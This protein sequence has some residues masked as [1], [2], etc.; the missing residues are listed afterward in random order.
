MLA[1]YPFHSFL[2]GL[3]PVLFLFVENLGQTDLVAILPP[4]AAMMV[5]LGFLLLVIHWISGDWTSTGVYAS[6]MVA[7]FYSYGYFYNIC[8]GLT[9]NN[10][11]LGRERWLIPIWGLLFILGLVWLIKHR[12]RHPDINRALNLVMIVL[13]SLLLLKAGGRYYKLY[14]TEQ[15]AD[16]KVQSKTQQLIT[17]DTDSAGLKNLPSIYYIILDSYSASSILK[18]VYGYDNGQFIAY[19]KN[20]GFYVAE[21]SCCNYAFTSASL[22]SSLNLD[23]LDVIFNLR[24]PNGHTI[25]DVNRS[26][27]DSRIAGYFSQ[28]GYRIVQLGSWWSPTAKDKEEIG[29]AGCLLTEFNILLLRMTLLRPIV[30]QMTAPL[31]RH[32]IIAL[33]D[34]MAE[35]SESESPNFVFAHI[36]C[37]HPPYVFGAN[38]EAVGLLYST[39]MRLSP[40]MLYVNQMKAIN[41]KMESLF[42]ILITK[43]KSPPIIVIQADHGSGFLFHPIHNRAR[44]GESAEDLKF[45]KAQ[46]RI[47][48]AYYL[49]GGGEKNLYD[50]I[51]PVNTFRVILNMYFNG[52]FKL[53]P[54][55]NYYSN[56][57]MPFDFIDVTDRVGY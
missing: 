54:D 20:K 1:K 56:Y 38:G 39:A 47:L 6:L 46:F 4:V 7:W 49:P 18:D 37:P 53:R 13:M 2:V 26:I 32:G 8:I 44:P 28:R 51:S 42:E 15:K 5:L 16:G 12:R 3:F 45:L 36:I 35:L 41:K 19:L 40:Q 14:G 21:K 55:K 29:L 10:V 33:I 57:E 31:L 23:Y 50:T 22:A 9:L 52:N 27:G 25:S 17:R 34:R 11:V 48:N 24:G 30:D 43:S